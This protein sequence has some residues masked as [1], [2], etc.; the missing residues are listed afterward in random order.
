M[1]RKLVVLDKLEEIENHMNSV[2]QAMHTK[3]VTVET[4]E[5][6]LYQ[7]KKKLFELTEMIKLED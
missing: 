7:V 2:Y 4:M 5:R 1:K 3:D 6:Y